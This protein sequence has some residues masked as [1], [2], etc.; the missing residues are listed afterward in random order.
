[1]Q[2]LHSI[3][4]TSSHVHFLYRKLFGMLLLL[5]SFH[6]EAITFSMVYNEP[7]IKDGRINQ[8]LIMSRIDNIDQH[9]YTKTNAFCPTRSRCWLGIAMTND[10][11]AIVP[12]DGGTRLVYQ[13][14]FDGLP[15]SG[16]PSI[17][18]ILKFASVWVLPVGG[19]LSKPVETSYGKTCIGLVIQPD[20]LNNQVA[21][22]VDPAFFTCS[23]GSGGGIIPPPPQPPIEKVSCSIAPSITLNHKTLNLENLHNNK[24]TELINVSCDGRATVSL[25]LSPR[26]INLSSDGK[27][28][29]NLF[30]NDKSGTTSIIVDRNGHVSLSSVLSADPTFRSG[31]DFSNSTVLTMSFY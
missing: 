25:S 26:T 17:G 16:Q 14:R 3:L 31:G 29:S 13:V 20:G 27:L 15:Q 21:V 4:N 8:T 12:G 11:G 9:Y 28:K 2:Q 1:M 10:V 23:D 6:S 5:F 24:I 22:L 18:E 7:E 19:T 30:I